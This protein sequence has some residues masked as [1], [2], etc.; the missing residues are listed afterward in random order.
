MPKQMRL[1]LRQA[2]H[3]TKQAPYTNH[4]L[5]KYVREVSVQLFYACKSCHHVLEK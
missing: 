2:R 3:G 1:Y 5:K 4:F